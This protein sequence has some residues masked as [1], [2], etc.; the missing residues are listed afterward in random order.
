MRRSILYG[1]R[2]RGDLEL[3]LEPSRL[4]GDGAKAWARM[5]FPGMRL[6]GLADQL[7]TESVTTARFEIGT[8]RV[9]YGRTFRYSRAGEVLTDAGKSRLVGFGNYV[10]DAVNHLDVDCFIGK[11]YVTGG[12]GDTHL[13]LKMA[14]TTETYLEDHF[15]GGYVMFFNGNHM[16]HYIVKSDASGA[17]FCRIYLDHPLTPICHTGVEVLRRHAAL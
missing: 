2:V 15:Q 14:D 16:M 10:P 7:I 4:G 13:D 9:E 12:V 5:D 6:P 3:G 11:A 17:L 8:K 1:P